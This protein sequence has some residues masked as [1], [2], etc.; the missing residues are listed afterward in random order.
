[1]SRP[2][3]PPRKTICKCPE[4]IDPFIN[5]P[6]S[7]DNANLSTSMR[8]SERV[9]SLKPKKIYQGQPTHL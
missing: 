9:R 2:T 7:L 5:T 3:L 4:D 8:L 6:N 1:M